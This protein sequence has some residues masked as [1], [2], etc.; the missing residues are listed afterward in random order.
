MFSR[1][2]R[3][4]LRAIITRPLPSKIRTPTWTLL[5]AGGLTSGT[6]LLWRRR[7]TA[8]T[9]TTLKVDP[10]ADPTSAYG[11]EIPGKPFYSAEE[12]AKHDCKENRVWVTFRS[13]VYDVTD[14]VD[15]F[16][17]LFRSFRVH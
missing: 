2:F 6:W 12:V 3:Q 5:V 8:T 7:V 11:Q 13:G 9:A 4:H 10:N 15:G 17:V 16:V 14:F 1:Q